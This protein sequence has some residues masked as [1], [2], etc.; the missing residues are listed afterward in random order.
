LIALEQRIVTNPG[1]RQKV[2]QQIERKLYDDAAWLFLGN[3]LN[4]YAMNARLQWKPSPDEA[5]RLNR[6]TLKP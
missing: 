3:Y 4:V 1:Q 5:I 2:L 6:A